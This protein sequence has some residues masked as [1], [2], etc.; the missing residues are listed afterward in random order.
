[1]LHRPLCLFL[2]AVVAATPTAYADPVDPFASALPARDTSPPEG[3]ASAAGDGTVDEQ[4]GSASYRYPIAVPPGRNGMAPDLA[5]AYSSGSPLRGGIAAGWSMALP[6]IVRD[7]GSAHTLV[8]RLSLGG[9]SQLLVPTPNDPGPGT[10]Y[11]PELDDGF[12][13]VEKSGSSW[14]VKTPDGRTLTFAGVTTASD[15]T[16]RWNLTSERDAFGNE[17][18]YTWARFYSAESYMDFV[19]QRIEYT[20]N[21]AAGLAAHAKL[22]FVYAPTETCTLGAVP[23]G[24]QT[25]HHFGKKRMRGAQR[26]TRIDASVRDVAGG[27]WRLARRHA[28]TYDATAL[29]C[30]PR[31][32]LRFITR[33]DETAWSPA[34]VPTT[35][36]PVTFGYGPTARDLSSAM[37]AYG[38]LEAG[39]RQG[40]ESGLM[41]VDGDG[42]ADWVKVVMPAP[43]AA[44][45]RLQWH[46]GNFGGGFA[47]FPEE[48]ELPSA[49]W[50]DENNQPGE[51]DHCTLNGQF[52]TRPMDTWGNDGCRERAVQ[53]GYHFLDWDHDGDL[54]LLTSNWKVGGATACGDFPCLIFQEAGEPGTGGCNGD[55][56]PTGGVE[57]NQ[58]VCQ[59]PSGQVPKDGNSGCREDCG[60]GQVW[61]EQSQSCEE[62]CADFTDCSTDP[63]PP[64]ELPEIYQPESCMMS[65][66]EPEMIGGYVWRVYPN[67][68]GELALTPQLIE[69]PIALPPSGGELAAPQ[70]GQPALSNL[71]DIDGDGW[72]D[73]IEL[74]DSHIG[75]AT[76]IFV[77][78]GGHDL[79]YFSSAGEAT[80]PKPTYFQWPQQILEVTG[81]NVLTATTTV[82]MLDWDGDGL[83][84]LV[85][86]ARP[87]GA[88]D[89]AL[90]VAFNMG[91]SFGPLEPLGRP[92]PVAGARIE[93]P[94]GWQSPM[95]IDRGW[96]ASESHLFDLDADGLVE[97]M[98]LVTGSTVSATASQRYV[99]R[100]NGDTWSGAT[101]GY[102]VIWEAAERLVRA[103]DRRAWF[104][105]S[106][107]VDMTGDGQ[108]DLVTWQA[109]GLALVRTDHANTAPLRL[110]TTINNGRGG[111]TT[112]T[113]AAATD[114]SVVTLVPGERVAPQWLVK[115]VAVAPGHAQ[116]EQRT[117]YRYA[118]PTYGVSSLRDEG[119]QHFVGFG[120][121]TAEHSG[122]QGDAAR[123]TVKQYAFT[124]GDDRRARL[125][126][127][128]VLLPG[129]A[130]GWTAVSRTERTWQN[131]P[132]LGG[133]VSFTHPDKTTERTFG[134]GGA[135]DLVRITVEH[136]TPYTHNGAVVL[137]EHA[138]T[139]LG[140]HEP[141]LIY[142]ATVRDFQ[143]RLGQAPFPAADYRVLET[144]RE[145][146]AVALFPFTLAKTVTTY[147]PAAGLPI[148]TATHVSA[149]LA[150]RTA[151]TFDA[152]TGN[153]LTEKRPNQV[154]SGGTKV[155][156]HTYDGHRLHVA[157]T[158][159]E[160]GHTTNAKTDVATGAVTRRE[161]PNYR[162]VPNPSG[163]VSW[164]PQPCKIR[165]YEP[166]EWTI[167]GFGRVVEERV[168]VDPPSGTPGYALAPVTWVTYTDGPN[169]KRVVERLRDWGGSARLKEE[170]LLDG[171]GRV[172]RRFVRRQEPGKPD[173]ETV[174]TY[175]AGGALAAIRSPDPRTD[176]GAL[177]DHGYVR[178]GLGRVTQ[179]TRP[180]GTAEHTRHLGAWTERWT[181]SP[182]DGAGAVTRLV[183]D[184]HGRLVE[185][186]E[187]DNPT[188][189]AIA[190]TTYTHDALDRVGTI[191]DADGVITSIGHD[192]RGQRTNIIR[193]GRTWSYGYDLD[194]NQRE[195]R[196]PV[197]AGEDPAAYTSVSTFDEL[198][199]LTSHTP[200][201]RGMSSQ[202]LAE[203]GI[204]TIAYTYDAGAN[205]IGR[206]TRVAQSP[207]WQTDF[208]YDVHGKVAREQRAVIVSTGALVGATQW[209]DR[210]YDATGALRDVVWDDGTRWRYGYD[211]RGMVASVEWKPAGGVFQTVAGYD[212]STAG[213]PR[214]R[215]SA[216]DQRR[217]WSYD[218]LGRVTYDR[219]YRSSTDETLAEK[220]YGY[221]GFGRL[222]DVGGE[223]AGMD[224][225]GV[226]AYDAR[227]RVVSAQGPGSYSG[228]FGYTAAG[229]VAFAEVAGALDALD[230]AV[231]YAY[232]GVDPHA[233]SE[234]TDRAS[235]ATVGALGYDLQGNLT[236]RALPD[237]TIQLAW[238]G[239]D[240]L[241]EV[242]GPEGTEV[243]WYAGGAE[244]IAAIGPD[245][246]KLWFGESETH[247]ATDGTVLRRY[248]HVA[249]GEALARIEDGTTL[250]LQYADGLHNLMLTASTTGAVTGAFV[251]GAFGELVGAIGAEDHRRQFNGKEAD[252]VSGLRFYGYRHYDPALLRW[253]SADPLFRF[254]PDAA[255]AEPQRANLY[256]FSLNNPLTMYDPDGRNPEEEEKKRKKLPGEA[257]P[258]TDIHTESVEIHKAG[259]DRYGYADTKFSTKAM[260]LKMGVAKLKFDTVT[261]GR[262]VTVEGELTLGEIDISME[263]RTMKTS[264]GYTIAGTT[265]K[266]SVDFGEATMTTTVKAK[267]G[268]DLMT[269]GAPR[270]D[271][272][273]SMDVEQNGYILPVLREVN[274]PVKPPPANPFQ[275]VR[276]FEGLQGGT[277]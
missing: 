125:V 166:H 38:G 184:A 241:R 177:V 207:G 15:A 266:T 153:L 122:Q 30:G 138:E 172:V 58:P 182:Q 196:S 254:V 128:E 37:Y 77:H 5:L 39:M 132:L 45:C 205:A 256:A 265:I 157:T 176:D 262:G 221:D 148:E 197:P 236:S 13:R 185:V 111:V 163:C 117:T 215:S 19:L 158:V 7:S 267:V 258:H 123:R 93:Q 14:T 214:E 84:D 16:T 80:W 234:L 50:S 220:S 219:V 78:R 248:H 216:Y 211:L 252:R 47:Q 55:M 91:G 74:N 59:C 28:L 61:N 230:R 67:T 250:E 34:G 114:P 130:G 209:V 273:V 218:E 2:A 191:V 139:R 198:G 112:F 203:L 210:S 202:R 251:Y 54:D 160:L 208:T 88:T 275:E 259:D 104:R 83:V 261:V 186:H 27:A 247:F 169:S 44:R 131:R 222:L 97:Q 87:T 1:M 17:V 69:A 224:A 159:N 60:F 201:T 245:G 95:M 271:I 71:V 187:H 103:L 64:P 264:V 63:E 49:A 178:D 119:P 81:P 170:D 29:V 25:D 171:L 115:R 66:A 276:L 194:G 144:L 246:V 105:A 85:A 100:F 121:V 120:E 23:I 235:G 183:H 106:D 165:A 51:A 90:Y 18:I 154:A 72:L 4:H 269:L 31:P 137:Y 193:A 11:R 134:A 200:G 113:Y 116:P 249:A 110:L 53:V 162:V 22:D 41:D 86:D 272:D 192:W 212:R 155:T 3:I 99:Y 102:D 8:Y 152:Q 136:W 167:D 46:K 257:D 225:G 9:S 195:A 263:F 277:P 174:Y 274:K 253:T 189:G 82:T 108:P 156:A 42:I 26:L 239:D 92:G 133:L 40:P 10:R 260:S 89:H 233:V 21:A 24:A 36:P 190:V 65:E 244:R 141:L 118:R 206:S 229:N 188:P 181:E 135:P 140:D 48:T 150:A 255:W 149:T 62:D 164:P 173:A 73:L 129:A 126:S 32:P 68:G 6:E 75:P 213:A 243:Y 238:D 98:R 232:D 227:G 56:G 168:A 35:A 20:S 43:G 217:G 240:K 179:L 270:P 127:E 79:G 57:D 161:G 76:Q 12:T 142:R 107:F 101:Y 268:G 228:A 109:N 242:A 147:D 146:R 231:D 33:I 180:D 143:V 70:T 199:R 151:R 223:V 94:T 52:V 204:G 226:Y 145:E 124:L 96:R 175:D 237:A